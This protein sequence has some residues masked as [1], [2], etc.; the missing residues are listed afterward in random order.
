M[1]TLPL[2]RFVI[3]IVDEQV[4]AVIEKHTAVVALT[5]SWAVKVYDLAD[6]AER[7]LSHAMAEHAWLSEHASLSV[8]L[9]DGADRVGLHFAAIVMERLPDAGCVGRL[10]F[11]RTIS[12][13][14][15]DRI[16]VRIDALHAT[17]QPPRI[18]AQTISEAMRRNLTL[19]LLVLGE[20]VPSRI[21]REI[22]RRTDTAVSQ[23]QSSRTT[24]ATATVAHANL[25]GPNIFL[26]PDRCVLIDPGLRNADAR[27][28]PG[29]CEVAP[30]MADLLLHDLGHLLPPEAL[31]HDD[32]S[33]ELL[34][35]A[36]LI[37]ALVRLRF[38]VLEQ[39]ETS[40]LSWMEDQK[41]LIRETAIPVLERLLDPELTR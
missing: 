37:K 28:M 39:N 16:V 19:Q 29:I 25:F 14:D 6:D 13:S 36:V 20:L 23:W 1:M 27:W 9:H 10:M 7:R 15:V 11:E 33:R 34:R 21:E 2:E 4:E 41:I 24:P 31:L 35:V 17:A 22:R 18:Y 8:R 38:A 12:A 3:D 30:L 26:L 32:A 5:R 40:P